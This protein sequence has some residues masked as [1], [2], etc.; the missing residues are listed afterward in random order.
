MATQ[1]DD[2]IVLEKYSGNKK[3]P[4]VCTKRGF[5]EYGGKEGDKTGTITR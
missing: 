4:L 3:A 5:D 1:H 2:Y